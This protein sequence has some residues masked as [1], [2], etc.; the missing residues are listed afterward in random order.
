MK[1]VTPYSKNRN[2]NCRLKQKSLKIFLDKEVI[3]MKNGR[4]TVEDGLKR[5]RISR[6]CRKQSYP[7]GMA[8]LIGLVDNGEF[9][10]I[11]EELNV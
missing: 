11:K 5:Q 3:N 4:I 9:P 2:R 6:I 10:N 1:R 8:N 7:I